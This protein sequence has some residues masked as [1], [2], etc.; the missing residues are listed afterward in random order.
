MSIVTIN[1]T[2]MDVS[3]ATGLK[4]WAGM[5]AL[6]GLMVLASLFCLWMLCRLRTTQQHEKMMM[7][8]FMAIEAGQSPAAWLAA[9][10]E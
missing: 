4:E 2:R 6:A 10:R 9:L 5:G 8:A 3:L 7:H 1:S